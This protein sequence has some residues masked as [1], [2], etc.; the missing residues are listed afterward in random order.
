MVYKVL[1]IWVQCCL[2]WGTF[3]VPQMPSIWQTDHLSSPDIPTFT[4]RKFPL[5]FIQGSPSPCPFPFS[6]DE[7][8][9]EF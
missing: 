5:P 9:L 2:D 1:S 8:G 7:L 6:E 4:H 3:L